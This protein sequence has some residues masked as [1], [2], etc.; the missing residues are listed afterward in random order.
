L[1]P[2]NLPGAVLKIILAEPL[3]IPAWNPVLAPLKD[4]T[5]IIAAE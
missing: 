3:I 4:I 2:Y 5:D 1:E